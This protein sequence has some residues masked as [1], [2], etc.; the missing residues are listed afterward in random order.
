[1]N[2]TEALELENEMW[3]AARNRNDE[4]F[5][6]IV[7]PQAIMVCGGFRCLGKDYAEIIREFDCKSYEISDFEMVLAADDF[8]QVH[9][10]LK[11]KVENEQ[12]RDLEGTFHVTT[13]W[14]FSD[15]MWRVVFNM[16]QRI[17]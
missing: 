2:L 17:V 14:H 6:K 9:Y 11:M 8:F 12:N 5:S 1:M 13:T 7:S 3:K 10:V 15:G 4:D 16:D